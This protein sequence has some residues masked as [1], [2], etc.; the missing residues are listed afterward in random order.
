MWLT[1]SIFNKSF[2]I[3]FKTVVILMDSYHSKLLKTHNVITLMMK[4]LVIVSKI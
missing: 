2:S 1:F 3:I 4:I